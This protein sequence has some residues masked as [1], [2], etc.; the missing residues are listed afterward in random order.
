MKTF[1]RN[2]L[3]LGTDLVG[4]SLFSDKVMINEKTKMVKKLAIDK[5]IDKKRWTTAP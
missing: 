1:E 3:Y 5:D 4:I 2:F